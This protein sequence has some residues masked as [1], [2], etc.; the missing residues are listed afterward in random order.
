[1]LSRISLARITTQTTS[2]SWNE[3]MRHWVFGC[4]NMHILFIFTTINWLQW[5]LLEFINSESIFIVFFSRF[6]T[7]TAVNKPAG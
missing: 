4:P 7:V 1:M 2:K 3:T 6:Q 5:K